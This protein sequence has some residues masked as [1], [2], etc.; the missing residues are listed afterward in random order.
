MN[1][2]LFIHDY[3]K[4]KEDEN[5]DI[6]ADG[7]YSMEVWNRYICN[8]NKLTVIT[9]K[10]K[11]VYSKE[12]ANEL[13]HKIDSE[14]VNFVELR[15]RSSSIKSYINANLYIENLKLLEEEIQKSDY[16]IL[17][18]PNSYSNKIVKMCKKYKK[19]ILI[20]VVG[21]P[22]DAYW[23]HSF[24]GKLLSIPSYINMKR[25]MRRAEY[26]IYVTE[27]FLQKRYP[28]DGIQYSCSDVDLI[29]IDNSYI[30]ERVNKINS[31]NLKS[32]KIGTLGSIDIKQKGQEYVIKSIPLLNKLGINVEYELVGGKEGKYLKKIVKDLSL[33]NQVKFKGYMKHDEI[34]EWL[35]SIDV[36][37]QPSLQEGLPR[38][39]I[40]AMSVGCPVLGCN[41]GGIYELIQEECLL[42]RRCEEDIVEKIAN[43][44]LDKMKKY[45]KYNF[46]KSKEFDKKILERKRNNIIK[47]FYNN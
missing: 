10:D 2:V 44:T 22:F 28:T 45:A 31:T 14:L 1:K 16:I 3:A 32:L 11:K 5:G 24:K 43:L 37:I 6:Y 38:S 23:N 46:S 18:V 39:V 27:E 20:E 8:T 35:K 19:S 17:R 9:R 12:M 42:K 47:N 26:S 29:S 7:S 33:E 30:N 25:T 15:D 36:Y 4:L 13:F 41:T 21:C 34:F 40:E